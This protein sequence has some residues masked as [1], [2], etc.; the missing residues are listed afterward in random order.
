[1]TLYIFRGISP[2]SGVHRGNFSSM[3]FCLSDIL[4]YKDS[5]VATEGVEDAAGAGDL[6][7]L[8]H[9]QACKGRFFFLRYSNE[10]NYIFSSL[11]L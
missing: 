8:R 7:Q 11:Y 2:S 3:I 5:S 10:I 6:S 1:M 9:C 4:K